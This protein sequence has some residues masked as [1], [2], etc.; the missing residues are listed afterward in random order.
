MA[1]VNI[2]SC[3]FVNAPHFTQP[4]VAVAIVS[5]LAHLAVGLP[6]HTGPGA[7]LAPS[8]PLGRRAGYGSSINK[9]GS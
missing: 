1:C 5:G 9:I 4:D 3:F 8:V 6:A 7:P 2:P